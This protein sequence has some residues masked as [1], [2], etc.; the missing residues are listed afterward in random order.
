MCVVGQTAGLTAVTNLQEMAV[1]CNQF[2][3][4]ELSNGSSRLVCWIVVHVVLRL[5]LHWRRWKQSHN[6]QRCW[7]VPTSCNGWL[8]VKLHTG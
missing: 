3:I 1:G 2:S 6:A 8:C 7:P 5:D 4:V